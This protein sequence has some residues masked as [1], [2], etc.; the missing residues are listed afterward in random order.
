M[1]PIRNNR[2]SCYFDKK[3]TDL[4]RGDKTNS[5]TTFSDSLSSFASALNPLTSNVYII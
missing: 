4:T 2:H 3:S 5:Y 1:V